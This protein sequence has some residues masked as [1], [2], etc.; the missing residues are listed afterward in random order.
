M[1]SEE[2]LAPRRLL[3]RLVDIEAFFEFV[4]CRLFGEVSMLNKLME[5]SGVCKVCTMSRDRY[6]LL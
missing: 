6:N 3:S 4:L 2:L 5:G 1:T